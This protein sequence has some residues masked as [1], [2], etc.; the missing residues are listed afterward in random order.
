M[1]RPSLTISSPRET[2]TAEKWKLLKQIWKDGY[3]EDVPLFGRL[4]A[5]FFKEKI[6]KHDDKLKIP[7]RSYS[8][9]RKRVTLIYGWMGLVLRKCDQVSQFKLS[10]NRTAHSFFLFLEKSSV[11]F[12]INGER[13]KPP[14][15]QRKLDKRVIISTKGQRYSSTIL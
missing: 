2:D 15:S 11:I 6:R 10:F 8:T 9:E 13:E 7:S 5:Y 12:A 4:A 1:R 14:Y 3:I